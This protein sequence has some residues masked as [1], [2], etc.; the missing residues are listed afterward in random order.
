MN[1]DILWDAWYE[2]RRTAERTCIHD[3]KKRAGGVMKQEAGHTPDM[4]RT[5]TG[6]SLDTMY[7]DSRRDRNDIFVLFVSYQQEEQRLVL[8]IPRHFRLFC[9]YVVCCALCVVI[10]VWW[11]ATHSRTH[12]QQHGCSTQ[13]AS[14]YF[15][16][17]RPSSF[18]DDVCV[19][20][21]RWWWLLTEVIRNK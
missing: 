19:I 14:H 6:H 3:A 11:P 4:H 2:R 21:D 16:C 7:D 10:S 8:A 1:I 12:T 9:V 13:Q 15:W 17:G 18:D 5:C 20:H